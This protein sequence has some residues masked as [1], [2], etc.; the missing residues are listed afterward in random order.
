AIVA[1]LGADA[2][3]GALTEGELQRALAR[4]VES[5]GPASGREVADL[6]AALTGDSAAERQLDL[7]LRTG[8]YGDWFGAVEDGL[9]LARLR[10]HPHGVDLGPLQPRIPEILRTPSGRIELCP[11]P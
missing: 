3:I 4:L 5:A 8:P 1:G 6:R 9:S 11:G 2:D 7:M 10:A